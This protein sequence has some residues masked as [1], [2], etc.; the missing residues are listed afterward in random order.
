[1]KLSIGESRRL[2]L[3]GRGHPRPKILEVRVVRVFAI[4]A[5]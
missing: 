5:L 4:N 3:R 1:M 2:A